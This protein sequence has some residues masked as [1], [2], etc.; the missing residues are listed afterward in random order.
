MATPTGQVHVEQHH[1]G[2]VRGDRGDGGVDVLRLG[3]DVDVGAELGH[4][5]ARILS[6]GD[7]V[8]ELERADPAAPLTAEEDIC[9]DVEVAAEG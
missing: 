7:A 8:Q 5:T 2:V 9:R 4:H 1:V 3:H 6:H